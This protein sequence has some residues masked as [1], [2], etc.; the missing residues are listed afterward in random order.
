MKVDDIKAFVPSKDYEL[1]KAFYEEIGFR[2]ET[3]TDDLTLF[4]NGDCSFFLQ[5][6][7]HPDLAGNF[8]L[9]VCV[10]DIESAYRMCKNAK[11]KSKISDVK[12]ES[13]GRVFYLWGPAGELLHVTQL[14]R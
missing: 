12:H 2:S 4:E 5:R 13:W 7:Y 11:H 8:M 9:Q 10:E 6:F 14:N 3:V 1:S